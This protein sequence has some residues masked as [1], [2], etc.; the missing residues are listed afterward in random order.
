MKLPRRVFVAWWHVHAWT[1][2][3]AGLVLAAMFLGGTLSVF[4]HEIMVWQDPPATDI[5]RATID[6]GVADA[7][8]ARNVAGTAV[9]MSVPR[10]SAVRP[11]LWLTRGDT[12]DEV[13]VAPDRE[14]AGPPTSRLMDV[15]YHLH[16]MWHE[17]VPILMVIAGVFGVLFLLAVVT[18]VAIH[19]KDIDR[20]MYRFR[21]Q[22][23]PRT[24]W[25]DVHKILGVWGLLFQ[26][27]I[28]MTGALICFLGLLSPHIGLAVYGGDRAAA[29][30]SVSAAEAVPPA[31]SGRP[32]PSLG[33]GTLAT[34]AERALPGMEATYVSVEPWGDAAAVATVYGMRDG[35]GLYPEV[36]VRLRARDG[37][38]LGIPRPEDDPIAH[39]ITHAVYGLH[40]AGYGGIALR[41]LYVLLGL[42]GWIT[43]LTGNW[44]WIERRR[45]RGRTRGAEILARLTVGLGG[46]MLV[47]AAA[48]FWI[49]RLAAVDADRPALEAYG[50]FTVWGLVALVCALF[51][52]RTRTWAILGAVAGGALL[53]VPALSVI[54]GPTYAGAAGRTAA[55]V[56]LA[57]ALVG[58]ALLVAARVLRRVSARTVTV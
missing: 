52:A 32:A 50:F 58:A 51:P 14:V 39:R 12:F 46:G 17:D 21:P 7:L 36:A 57:L 35:D 29:T 42:A 4:R 24:V 48:L 49:N 31:S 45:A 43:I 44:I 3:V 1:G 30:A 53:L 18:G 16:F 34:A 25:S 13:H 2:V 19:L 40:F 22:A 23:A 33:L 11:V 27:M 8:A 10:S 47:A 28:A 37:A 20:Q 55:L 15:F 9:G 54:A 5:D 6:R 56:D 38:V 26:L 41:S